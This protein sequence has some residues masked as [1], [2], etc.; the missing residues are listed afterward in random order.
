MADIKLLCALKY[1]RQIACGEI[2]SEAK[3][4]LCGRTG[5]EM[6]DTE[7]CRDRIH[8]PVSIPP[9]FSASEVMG[10]TKGKRSPIIFDKFSNMK[11]RYGNRQFRRRGH[12]ADTAGRNKKAMEEYIRDQLQEDNEYERLTTKE[13]FDPVAGEPATGKKQI[14]KGSRREKELRSAIFCRLPVN[15][16]AAGSPSERVKAAGLWP[17]R[18]QIQTTG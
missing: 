8:M 10:Y 13:L 4:V 17:L 18:S 3:K 16:L 11:Y 15:R 12:C 1:L 7:A 5:T 2:Q 6:I 9:G 14:Q